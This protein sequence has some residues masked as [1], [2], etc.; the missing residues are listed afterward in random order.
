M[1]TASIVALMLV[2]AGVTSCAIAPTPALQQKRAEIVRTTPVCVDTQDCKVKW[3]AAQLWIVKNAGYKLQTVTDVLLQT[4]NPTGSTTD[5]GVQA[6]KEPM[7]SG[8]YQ[9]V[10]K[11]W[12]DNM[13]G[14]FPNALDATLAFNREVGAAAL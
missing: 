5:I 4:Y 13:F 8:H 12:C 3:D 7:G 14:C 1:K 6:T 2:S 9:I 11:V 10:V